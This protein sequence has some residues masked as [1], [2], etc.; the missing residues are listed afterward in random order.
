MVDFASAV[1]SKKKLISNNPIKIYEL[2]D[3]R[4][5]TGPL[6]NVQKEILNEW[7]KERKEDKDLII[8]LDTG[9]GK[10]LIGLL[11]LQSKLNSKEGPC[12]YL[13]PNKYLVEQVC[14]EAEKFGIN[15]CKFENS[16][17]PQDFESGNKILI[18]TVQKLFN[19]KTVFGLGNLYQEVGCLIMDDSHACI[20]AISDAF[21]I[22]IIKNKNSNMKKIYDKIFYLFKED[23]SEQREGS[24]LDIESGESETIMAIPYWAWDKK[25]NTVLTILNQYKSNDEIKFVWPFIKD[26]IKNYK[27][28]INGN[29]IELTPY[30]IPIKKFKSFYNA[31]NRIF[32][33]ATTQNDAFFIKGLE[34]NK[35]AI[36]NPLESKKVKWTGEKMILIPSSIDD[37]FNRDDIIA[38]LCNKKEHKFG[39]VVLVSS[40][41]KA[42]NYKPY[43][44]T[45][46]N[47]DNIFK[48]INNLKLKDKNEEITVIVNRYDGID[49][50]DNACRVLV[51]D[52]L[53]YANS[54]DDRYNELC[55]GNSDIINIKIAQKIEQGLGRSV[56]GEKDY[57]AIILIGTELVKFIMKN[58]NLKYFSN[59]TRKQIEIG[60]KISELAKKDYKEYGIENPNKVIINLIDQ[61]VERDDGWKDFYEMQMESIKDDN[62]EQ[63]NILDILS[64]EACAQKDFELNKKDDAC[65]KIQKIIDSIS[66]NDIEEGWYLQELARYKYRINTIESNEVQM[67]AFSRNSELLKPREGIKYEKIGIINSN[68]T[69]KIKEFMLA[70]NDYQDFKIES[71]DLIDELYFGQES[72]IFERKIDMLGKMLGFE[73]QRPD[74][75]IRKGP[76]NLWY[77]GNRFYIMFECKSE[78]DFNRKVIYKSESGQV[79][80]HCGWFREEYKDDKMLPVLIIPTKDLSND[81]NF[82]DDVKIMRKSELKKLK[83]N[84]KK[85][86]QS[87][88]NYDIKNLNNQT[89]SDLLKNNHLDVESIKKEYITDFYH[90]AK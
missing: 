43:K 45:I 11:I 25:S 31:K 63:N 47:K 40:N 86:V 87:L 48:T 60:L 22:N 44:A 27:A 14:N 82:T 30:L 78:V 34:L 52:S 28:Y 89:I 10:T 1:K 68:R 35:E 15:Y 29:K 39:S 53:P 58:K 5:T 88:K 56:R 46:V 3:R 7:F 38:L 50:P 67:A 66:D 18:T 49:L 13:C 79:N 23:L 62:T 69:E 16:E 36:L 6:R 17:I 54:L 26:N 12:L 64:L 59:Q 80:N 32:M 73:T 74:K 21:T 77:L 8:K 90:L 9:V 33:S 42:E 65:K 24:C 19:G 85:Y 2:L 71:D 41:K 4:T 83:D 37:N 57:S 51:L 84:V 70:Y 76:D 61:L 75:K 20:D 55:R 81:A 72:E